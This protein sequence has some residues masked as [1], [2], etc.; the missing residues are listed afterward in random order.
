MK[1]VHKKI[2]WSLGSGAILYNTV[3][4]Y[5][6]QLERKIWKQDMIRERTERLKAKPE[7]VSIEDIDAS[8]PKD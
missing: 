8:L 2:V 3:W 6:W 1:L 5:N 4:A 7:L